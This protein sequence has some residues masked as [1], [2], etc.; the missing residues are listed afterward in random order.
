METPYWSAFYSSESDGTTNIDVKVRNML[1]AVAGCD[2]GVATSTGKDL[3]YLKTIARKECILNGGYYGGPS[4]VDQ[5]GGMYGRTMMDNLLNTESTDA[6]ESTL[7]SF[8]QM[9]A[10]MRQDEAVNPSSSP[11]QTSVNGNTSDSSTMSKLV[12]INRFSP[13]LYGGPHSSDYSPYHLRDYFKDDSLVTYQVPKISFVDLSK[14]VKSEAEGLYDYSPKKA[15]SYLKEGSY[16]YYKKLIYCKSWITKTFEGAVSFNRTTLQFEAKLPENYNGAKIVYDTNKL[17]Y[18]T[19]VYNT[20]KLA[21]SLDDPWLKHAIKKEPN[22]YGAEI[23]IKVPVC[24]GRYWGFSEKT[25]KFYEWA[26]IQ[27]RNGS[28]RLISS[29]PTTAMSVSMIC[30]SAGFAALGLGLSALK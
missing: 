23:F 4:T 18:K 3:N 5:N 26:I 8:E 14:E 13:A 15:L 28:S 16:S 11:A 10:S 29:Y 24:E 7:A 27:E 19:K 6:A 20:R 9:A 17:T 2:Y 21:D 22:E 30:S 25:V 12:G 1:T